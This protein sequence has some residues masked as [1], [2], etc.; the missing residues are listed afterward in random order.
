MLRKHKRSRAAR[1]ASGVPESRVTPEKRRIY[2]ATVIAVAGP[3]LH[4]FCL[5]SAHLA[6]DFSEYRRW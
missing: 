4:L 2:G 6:A 3:A 5:L 1:R